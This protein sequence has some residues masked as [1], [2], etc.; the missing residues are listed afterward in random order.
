MDPDLHLVL[1]RGVNVG[2]R[3]LLPMADFQRACLACGALAARTYIQSGN[4]LVR[5]PTAAQS[6]FAERLR[7]RL[8]ASPGVDSPVIR[9]AVGELAAVRACLPFP[10]AGPAEVHYALL[11]AVPAPERVAALD[12]DRSP[13]DRFAV[14]DRAVHL[15]LPNGVARTKLTNAWLDRAL[16]VVSTVRNAA[17]VDALLRLADEGLPA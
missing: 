15:H 10:D 3:N 17:T 5:L 8:A 13:G 16:G 7:E 4:A 14:I 1:L 9:M 2:G 6:G 12:P 11:S